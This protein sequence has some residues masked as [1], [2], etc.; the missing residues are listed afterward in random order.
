MG[1]WERRVR[2]KEERRRQIV[3][4][5]RRLFR[6]RGYKATTIPRIAEA[7]E[8]APGTLYLYFPGKEALYIELLN[9]GYDILLARLRETS[10]RKATPRR[11]AEALMDAFTDF[12]REQPDYFDMIF[13]VLQSARREIRQ[14]SAHRDLLEKLL[15]REKA[16]KDFAAAVLG[17]A[18]PRDTAA[19]RAL[20]VE[21]V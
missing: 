2:E 4:A 15:V 16:C 9:E 14:L 13:F 8:L 20:Q 11:Q 3:N 17:R 10:R 12:A 19:E 7:A 18:R 5:A 6:E 1:T 21:A